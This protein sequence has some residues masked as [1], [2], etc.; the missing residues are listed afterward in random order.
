MHSIN[1]AIADDDP[2]VRAA[3]REYLS[4]SPEFRI[5]GEADDGDGA[6]AL[7]EHSPLD[8]LLLDL[9]M[10][11]VNGL[12]VL[13]RISVGAPHV[14]VVVLSAYAAG[15]VDSEEA[16]SAVAAFLDKGCAPEEILHTVR[17]VAADRRLR[18][19]PELS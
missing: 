18:A 11:R 7:A 12:E 13:R 19:A 17:A 5:V 8:V 14:G 15:S 1:V 10:P 9:S 4:G 3:L 16:W 2:F 6:L